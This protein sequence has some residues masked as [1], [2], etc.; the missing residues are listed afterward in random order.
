MID[1]GYIWKPEIKGH[2]SLPTQLQPEKDNN[3]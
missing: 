1:K 2:W 3:K